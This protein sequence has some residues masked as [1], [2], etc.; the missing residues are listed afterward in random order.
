MAR[1][2]D[3]LI[4]ASE[5][6]TLERNIIY[7]AIRTV[8]NAR[9]Q[10]GDYRKMFAYSPGKD[11]VNDIS[12]CGIEEKEMRYHKEEECTDHAQNVPT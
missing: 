6:T 4:R 5:M 8:E 3:W 2:M 11:W 1:E 12:P 9:E 10:N 7:D